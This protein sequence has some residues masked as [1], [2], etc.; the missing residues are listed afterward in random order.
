MADGGVIVK[1]DKEFVT[2]TL[3]NIQTTENKIRR[4][5]INYLIL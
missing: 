5:K 3:K 1:W 2:N 4:I